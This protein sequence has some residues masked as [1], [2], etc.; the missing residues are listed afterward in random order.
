MCMCVC[1]RVGVCLTV[2]VCVCVCV[3]N[4]FYHHQNQKKLMALRHRP[5][6][7]PPLGHRLHLAIGPSSLRLWA[8]GPL[9][10]SPL[11]H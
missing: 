10:F 6:R 8:L 4:I 11:P 5:F 9:V 1:R 2:L 3:S 7:Y